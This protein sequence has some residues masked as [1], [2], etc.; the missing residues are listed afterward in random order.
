MNSLLENLDDE[1]IR[2]SIFAIWALSSLIYLYN[3]GTLNKAAILMLI[4]TLLILAQI[5]FTK[6]IKKKTK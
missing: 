6:K 1:L 5:H 3:Y 4:Y 2:K